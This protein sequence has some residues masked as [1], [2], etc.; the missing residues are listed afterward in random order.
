M[1]AIWKRITATDVLIQTDQAFRSIKTNRVD[2]SLCIHTYLKNL[3]EIAIKLRPF[4]PSTAKEIERL[5]TENQKPVAP[6]FLRK[7]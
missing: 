6:L 4:L 7:Q 1:D 5:I 3:I 2:A